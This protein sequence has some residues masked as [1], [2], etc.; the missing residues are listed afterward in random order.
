MYIY[1]YIC[2]IKSLLCSVYGEQDM[3]LGLQKLAGYKVAKRLK[4]LWVCTTWVVFTIY[5]V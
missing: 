5:I 2:K 3:G 1:I 4:F